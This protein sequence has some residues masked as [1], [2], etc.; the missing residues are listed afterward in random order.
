MHFPSQVLCS[1][2]LQDN[3]V[4]K[5][6]AIIHIILHAAS[7]LAA[8]SYPGHIVSY[9]PGDIR[10]CRLDATRMI[11][12]NRSPG[13]HYKPQLVGQ[14]HIMRKLFFAVFAFECDV[15]RP[16]FHCKTG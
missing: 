1:C 9:A 8:S 15:I 7:S 6:P 16:F 13:F 12:C 2:F 4:K 3:S 5:F 10:T 11:S 14:H